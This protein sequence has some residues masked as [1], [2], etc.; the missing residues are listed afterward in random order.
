MQES[1]KGG[2]AAIAWLKEHVRQGGDVRIT[3]DIADEE[4]PIVM[5]GVLD[6]LFWP[7]TGPN[8]A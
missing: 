6:I 8:G 4:D 2:D 5:D 1:A 7:R 3:W